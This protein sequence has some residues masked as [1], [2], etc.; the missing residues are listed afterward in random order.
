MG[1]IFSISHRVLVSRYC[2]TKPNE[3]KK[4]KRKG[5]SNAKDSF[6]EFGLFSFI[7]FNFFSRHIAFAS[8]TVS[9]HEP[10]YIF[11][12]TLLLCFCFDLYWTFFSLLSFVSCQF[13]L[14]CSYNAFRV[15]FIALFFFLSVLSLVIRFSISQ[16]RS[17]H[18]Q[19][20][21]LF[22]CSIQSLLLLS[23]EHWVFS[24]LLTLS[25]AFNHIRSVW[26]KHSI[27]FSS[28]GVYHV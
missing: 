10:K 24:S 19:F 9:L 3:K 4:P 6:V 1:S 16:S 11:T 8:S 7:R 14:F 21:F 18:D 26:L 12:V 2:N 27:R 17:F 5:S 28:N 20:G 13:V 22:C 23:L 15:V 25:N